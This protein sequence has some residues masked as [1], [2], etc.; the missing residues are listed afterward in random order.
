MSG[1]R[2]KE[3]VQMELTLPNGHRGEASGPLVQGVETLVAARVHESPA[4]V[5][6]IGNL[7]NL[8][9]R[10]VRDPYARWCGR[11][12]VVRPP[13]IPIVRDGWRRQFLPFRGG[14][15][16]R[17]AVRLRGA[18]PSTRGDSGAKRRNQT[19]VPDWRWPA[20]HQRRLM[21]SGHTM[22]SPPTGGRAPSD[23]PDS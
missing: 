20:G 2:Q 22:F 21:I 5:E 3:S 17:S 8:P 1:Q 12:A 14:G 13:P 7:H 11:A 16:G 18:V 23:A 15:G 4:V 6:L 19:A 10:R 9:N